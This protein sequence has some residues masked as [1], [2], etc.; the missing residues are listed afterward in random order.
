MLQRLLCCFTVFVIL[1]T[2]TA[3][4]AKALTSSELKET[5]ISETAILMDGDTGQVLFEKDGQKKMAPASI[6]KIMTALLALENSAPDSMITMS[7]D[8]VFSIGRGTS[9]IALDVGEELSLKDALY[10]LA[11][12]SAND[13]ANGIAEHISGSLSGFAALMNYR[14]QKAGAINTNF[15]NAHGLPDP[16]HYTTAYDMAMITKAALQIPR[17]REIFSAYQ[18]EMPP[19]NKQDEPRVFWRNN[20]L[21]TGKYKYQGVIAT[22]T[23]WTRDSQHTL[24]TAAERDGRTLIAVVMKSSAPNDKWQDTVSLLDYGFTELTYVNFSK[25]ELAKEHYLISEENGAEIDAGLFAD[26]DFSCLIPNSMTKADIKIQYIRENKISAESQK[27]KAVF[28]L[29]GE[30]PGSVFSEL[31]EL[32]MTA[33]DN[34]Y[35]AVSADLTA[36]GLIDK[37]GWPLWVLGI[38][39]ILLL[40]FVFLGIRR[41]I[42]IKRRWHSR[43]N[44]YI[45][46]H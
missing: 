20:S 30:D 26:K 6:T 43:V 11:I 39:G 31:G 4:P 35:V 21:L 29:A 8:A 27:V 40:F 17:F 44:S 3:Y 7:E 14:A 42:M 9:H 16:D 33:L 22:K 19:T 45:D 36:G 23:G 41:E 28:S 32:E 13:A 10:A 18:Y 37:R 15:T 1:L 12:E 2:S 46:R 5:L 34:N 38:L 24:V 25:E